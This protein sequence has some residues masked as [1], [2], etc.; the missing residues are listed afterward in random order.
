MET[1]NFIS[2][3]KQ[4]KS[5]ALQN[6]NWFKCPFMPLSLEQLLLTSESSQWISWV[7]GEKGLLP[8]SPP[9]TK[10]RSEERNF[11]GWKG[12]V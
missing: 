12:G 9:N 1:R 5:S 4:I 11:G 7:Y 10:L 3:T 6:F 2:K 8:E